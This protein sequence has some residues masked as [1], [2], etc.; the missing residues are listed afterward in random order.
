MESVLRDRF[1]VSRFELSSPAN[2]YRALANHWQ[3]GS[4][5]SLTY[6]ESDA[7]VDIA[8]PGCDGVRLY[9]GLRG[10]TIQG[11]P[12]LGELILPG[13]VG[14]IGPSSTYI[15][16]Y[17]EGSSLLVLRIGQPKLRAALRTLS[18]RYMP[19]DITFT[20]DRATLRKSTQVLR[21]LVQ[22]LVARA[23]DTSEKMSP[24]LIDSLTE[25]IVVSLLTETPNS[26]SAALEA[27]APLLGRSRMQ[28]AEDFIEAN[29]DQPLTVEQIAQHAS[30]SVRTLF[31]TFQT[32]HGIG[33][34]VFLRKTRL[35]HARRMLSDPASL[36]TVAAVGA[37]CGFSNL[38]HFARYYRDH[39][40]IL[41]SVTLRS[42]KR[43]G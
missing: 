36:E 14:L 34:I 41:P 5:V 16:R 29:W 10:R 32:V 20:D 23:D 18:G 3:P 30:C 40:G 8:L 4:D 21:Q 9:L 27:P 22:T 2:A 28:L 19:G 15:T 31:K 1:G 6:V 13:D 38:G 25:S 37:R 35:E 17:S 33:P 24:L 11:S 12:R 39:F 26:W 43:D 42:A 7:N